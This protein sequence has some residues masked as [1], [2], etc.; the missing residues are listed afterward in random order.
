MFATSLLQYAGKHGANGSDQ[1]VKLPEFN[2]ECKGFSG[3]SAPCPSI[4]PL[5][6]PFCSIV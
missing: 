1:Y 5:C 2:F 4:R 3:M 6:D